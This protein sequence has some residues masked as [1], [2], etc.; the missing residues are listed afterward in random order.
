MK[1]IYSAVWGL[2][3]LLEF[4]NPINAQNI[5]IMGLG[6]SIT[7]GD[8]YLPILIRML[9]DSGFNCDFVGIKKGVTSDITYCH[10]GFGGKNTEYIE[11][12]IDSIYRT[13][14]ADIV[15]LHSGHNHFIE[16]NPVSQI[17]ESHLSIIHKIKSINP[18]AI[19]LVAGVIHSGKLPKYSYIPLLNDELEYMVHKL[20]DIKVR[21]VKVYENFDWRIHT[22]KDK[23]HPNKVGSQVM[24][25]N[26]YQIINRII[27]ELIQ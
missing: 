10:S 3:M 7:E 16:E 21:Y 4:A 27:I 17:I 5:R 13:A 25:N 18:K 24:A 2:L 23:V 6:D 19:I 26:W 11:E 8:Y 9:K 14:P 12:R 1:Y 20:N 22:L 15:L